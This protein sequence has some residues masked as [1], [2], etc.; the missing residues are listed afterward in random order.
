MPFS[1]GFS[2]FPCPWDLGVAQTYFLDDQE[3]IEG[4]ITRATSTPHSL[5]IL[6]PHRYH[7]FK[8]FCPA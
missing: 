6:I 3:G 8:D 1:W 7:T 5:G 4:P 2:T